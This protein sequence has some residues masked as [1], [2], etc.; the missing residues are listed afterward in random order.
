MAQIHSQ[1]QQLP[2]T[3]PKLGQIL[4]KPIN[5]KYRLDF[6]RNCNNKDIN[7]DFSKSRIPKN[8]VFSEQVE[9]SFQLMHLRNVIGCA[10]QGRKLFEET[11]GEDSDILKKELKKE[12]LAPI[13][14]S[15]RMEMRDHCELFSKRFNDKLAKLSEK[16]D[17]FLWNKSHI[18]V[19]TLDGVELPK[20]VLDVLSLGPK[21]MPADLDRIFCQFK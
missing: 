8:E 5:G 4:N 9:H 13:V 16:Q 19:V 1:E 3:I 20:F 10:E 21:H 17:R 15:K 12:L 11:L 18:N 6:L 14:Y 2:K 7:P